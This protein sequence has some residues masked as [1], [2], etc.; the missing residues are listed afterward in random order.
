MASNLGSIKEALELSKE[1]Q[2]SVSLPLN[3]CYGEVAPKGFFVVGRL[4]GWRSFNFEAL[5]NTITNAFNPIRGLD[6]RL[7]DIGLE[8]DDNPS[9][10]ELDRVDRVDFMVHVHDLPLRSM[11]REMA[12]FVG[13][14]LG[15]SKENRSSHSRMNIYRIFVIGCGRLGHISNSVNANWIRGLMIRWILF[16]LVRGSV[17]SPPLALRSR[18]TPTAPAR[19]DFVYPGHS[20]T[21]ILYPNRTG[22]NIFSYTP[23]PSSSS[24]SP[25]PISE[26]SPSLTYITSSHPN[27]TTIPLLSPYKHGTTI[28]ISTY[29]TTSTI[30]SPLPPIPTQLAP[31]SMS[32]NPPPTTTTHIIPND[33]IDIP[34]TFLANPHSPTSQSQLSSTQSN[35]GR[36]KPGT[37]KIISISR[38]RKLIDEVLDASETPLKVTKQIDDENMDQS[39][40][41]V[42]SSL[43]P[44]HFEAAWCHHMIVRP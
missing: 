18:G 20:P 25:S 38:K 24:H 35:K 31:P 16:R 43:Q 10:I 5:K 41:E 26:S 44:F 12:E 2:N 33:L 40:Q 34:L 28:S 4:L 14:Q 23:T 3:L 11:T 15:Q 22:A 29:G 39:T 27:T 1:E 21:T 37:R 30:S 42:T 36:K 19:P 7:I 8:A 17:A 13:N 6:I 9:C 32:A